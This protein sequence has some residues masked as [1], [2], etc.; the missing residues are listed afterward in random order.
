MGTG[1]A[2]PSRV[3][4]GITPSSLAGAWTALPVTVFQQ[5]ATVLSQKLATQLAVGS[6][7]DAGPPGPALL[8]HETE[9]D[10]G[11]GPRT[12]GSAPHREFFNELLTQDTSVRTS[13]PSRGQKGM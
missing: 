1:F 13:S 10:E 6:A 5:T 4:C 3:T 12:R 8:P 11:V 9:A 7:A 2:V